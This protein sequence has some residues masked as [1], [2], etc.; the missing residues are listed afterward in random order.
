[1]IMTLSMT[2]AIVMLCLS[3]AT[4]QQASKKTVPAAKKT[5]TPAAKK[6]APAKKGVTTAA[7]KAAPKRSATTW[8]NRQLAP[9]ADRYREI[10]TALAARGYLRNENATGVWNQ[11]SSDALKKFQS[12]QNIESSGK[13][14]S[15]SL[16]ALGLGPKRDPAPVIPPKPQLDQGPQR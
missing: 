2:A 10:Q 15:L 6:G 9:S 13:I 8:R 12:E 7:R 14:N 5:T 11:E 3:A 1:M 16:I 4:A